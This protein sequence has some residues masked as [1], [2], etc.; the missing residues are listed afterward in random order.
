M[1]RSHHAPQAL[2][3]ACIRCVSYIA[4]Q[5]GRGY[6]PIASPAG[7]RGRAW[8]DLGSCVR[9]MAA[10]RCL[11]HAPCLLR[12][13]PAQLPDGPAFAGRPLLPDS[14]AEAQ[15]CRRDRYPV[16][17]HDRDPGTGTLGERHRRHPY[18][19]PVWRRS[20]SRHHRRLAEGAL[21][22]HS[23]LPS[24]F[25]GLLWRA[26][27]PAHRARHGAGRRQSRLRIRAVRPSDG[28]KAAAP[29]WHHCHG[30]FGI[31]LGRSTPPARS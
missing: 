20:L 1:A 12:G 8:R 3:E 24:Q 26:A 28:G 27:P 7:K 29:G 15:G 14:D 11:F 9:S 16:R 18:D 10:Q 19:G 21:G 5:P 2:A 22:H 6:P 4:G 30:Q 13:V 17:R 23:F 31:R 25:D